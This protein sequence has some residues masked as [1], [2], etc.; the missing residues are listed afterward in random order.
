MDF[1]SISILTPI[2]LGFVGFV[3]VAFGASYMRFKNA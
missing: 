2:V 1:V 3:V